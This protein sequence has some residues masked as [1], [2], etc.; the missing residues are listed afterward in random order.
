MRVVSPAA[1][2][3]APAVA[4]TAPSGAVVPPP[5]RDLAVLVEDI[6]SVR[7]CP[8]AE[9]DARVMRIALRLANAEGLLWEIQTGV[10][11]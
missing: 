7:Y 4:Q 3:A 9:V 5:V 2:A 10:R 11:T 6:R 8:L 1:G